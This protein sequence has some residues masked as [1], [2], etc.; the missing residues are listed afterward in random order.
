MTEKLQIT[1]IGL[2]EHEI[3]LFE[4]DF[5]DWFISKEENEGL[6]VNFR[7]VTDE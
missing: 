2:D 5:I 4:Q 1:I 3:P 7:V 6:T